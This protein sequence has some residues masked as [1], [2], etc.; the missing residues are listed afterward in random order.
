MELL[1]STYSLSTKVVASA[2]LEIS[3]GILKNITRDQIGS[4]QNLFHLLVSFRRLFVVYNFFLL[5]KLS[6]NSVENNL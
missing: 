6:L 4:L 5:V 3:F 1:L 2:A